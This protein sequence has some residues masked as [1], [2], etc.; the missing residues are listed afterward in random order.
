M[1]LKPGQNSG[2]NGGIYQEIG[3]RNG[4]RNNFATIP[5]NKPA[6]PTTTPG[7]RWKPIDRTP[8]GTR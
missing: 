8:H 3:P 6:P 7:A 5:E 1:P 2:R 4:P